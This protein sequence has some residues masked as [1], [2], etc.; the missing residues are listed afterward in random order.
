MIKDCWEREENKIK[1]PAGWKKKS[2]R[3]LTINDTTETR[4]KY[5][6]T[7]RDKF[8][9]EDP[10]IWIAD[11]GATVH[12]TPHLELLSDN[13][14]PEE[15][16]TVVMGNG[17]EE[18][19]TT[20]GTVK[21]NAINKNGK[22]Q[23]SIDLS[24]IMNLKNGR[25]NL[26][27]VTKIMNSGWKLEGNEKS[28]SLVKE[29][30]KLIFD[31][32]IHTTRGVLFEVKI[33]KRSEIAGILKE[34]KKVKEVTSMEAHQCLGHLSQLST[35]DTEKQLGWHLTGEFEKC[36]DC[37]IGKGRQL[38]V[39]LVNAYFWMLH[40]SK[41][42]KNLTIT[43]SLHKNNTGKSWWMKSHNLR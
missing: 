24:G 23:G 30:K 29:N 12:T 28:I 25:Y 3:G 14:S 40:W 42:S 36:E 35:K 10:S 9:V 19:V 15:D 6:W 17:N 4:I 11:T 43:W 31:I 32:K 18:K 27:S 39:W 20:I 26:L 33:D 5:G 1:R 41:N 7:S 21:G 2:E 16:I 8:Q 34:V 22:L 37:A 38:Q 13:R